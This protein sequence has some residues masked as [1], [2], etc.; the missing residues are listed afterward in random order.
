M[1]VHPFWS[2]TKQQNL[3]QK[4]TGF[5]SQDVWP[6][7]DIPVPHNDPNKHRKPRFFRFT[8]SSVGVNLELKTALRQYFIDQYWAPWSICNM[9]SL[10]LFNSFFNDQFQSVRIETFLLYSQSVWKSQFESWLLAKKYPQTT[11]SQK[12]ACSFLG[13][14]YAN[15]MDFYDDRFEWDKEH[16]NLAKLGIRLPPGRKQVVLNL[17]SIHPSWLRLRVRQ[18]LKLRVD[19]SAASLEKNLSSLRYFSQFLQTEGV[20]G[21]KQVNRALIQKF[22]QY[23]LNLKLTSNSTNQKAGAPFSQNQRAKVIHCLRQFLETD[24]I[25]A[26]RLIL[27]EDL[28]KKVRT[29]HA[30]YIPDRVVTQLLE[31]QAQLAEP[32]RTMLLILLEIGARINELCQ[33][34]IDCLSEDKEGDYYVTRYAH[35]QQ[36]TLTV[37]VSVATANLIKAAQQRAKENAGQTAN[38][39]FSTSAKTFN[40]KINEYIVQNN[41]SDDKGQLWHF[42]SKQ[43]R[44]T[45]GTRLIN[46][47]VSQLAVQR[48]LGHNSSQMTDVY[49]HLHDQTLKAE[50]FKYR[51]TQEMNQSHGKVVN[52]A[53][54][55]IDE[56][57]DL[58]HRDS[59]WLKQNIVAQ[60]L[61]NGF[62]ARP[63][64]EG[65][66]ASGNACLQCCHLRTTTGHLPI[67]EQQLVN[68][69]E[70]EQQAQHK[71][72]VRQ[73]QGHAKTSESLR[74]IITR[75]TEK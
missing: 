46:N 65:S 72:L 39:L 66:C 9:S 53:G 13:S 1:T 41:I 4:L 73:Q 51:Q 24:E 3:A 15:L 12:Q 48:F 55:I 33:L 30:D 32:F 5:W 38:F 10:N 19:L 49:A 59:Q 27:P 54:E 20:R 40:Q 45:V 44:H 23:L 21:P 61:P 68:S 36:K 34:S 37:P 60:A 29:S 70:L 28:P 43:C 16:V 42:T 14:V 18:Y 7:V 57:L 35:K 26:K 17:S 22:Y 25:F 2:R 31:N 52:A 63:L 64:T 11:K 58:D 6:A 8:A 50:V 67:L 69:V 47:G 62:C 56:D 75:L 71:G 74:T